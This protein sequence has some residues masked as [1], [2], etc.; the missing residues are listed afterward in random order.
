MSTSICCVS[1][2]HFVVYVLRSS[3]FGWSSAYLWKKNALSWAQHNSDEYSID[4]NSMSDIFT[5]CTSFCAMMR[6]YQLKREEIKCIRCMSIDWSH[7]HTHRIH[8][9]VSNL[10]LC[11]QSK[12]NETKAEEE[13][14]TD[15]AL[16]FVQYETNAMKL[17]T[18]SIE[19]GLALLS[20]L[21]EQIAI[22][23]KSYASWECRMSIAKNKKKQHFI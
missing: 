19:Y 9:S 13:T 8:L 11:A 3:Y 6:R 12:V 17:Y 23:W 14:T 21:I 2:R 22:Y 7:T 16:K 10:I 4:G 20:D 5:M 15:A 18:I 1:A